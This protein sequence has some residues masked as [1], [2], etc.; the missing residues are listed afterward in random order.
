[1]KRLI[2]LL[3][4]IAVLGPP[5]HAQ[6]TLYVSP[7]V[8]TDDPGGSGSV[9]FPW[10]VVSYKAGLYGPVPVLTLPQNTA[11]DAVHKMD[12]PGNWL[13]S[14][15]A[16]TELPPG[17]GVFFE[18]EDAILY[19]GSNYLMYF[20]GSAAG[21]PP[22]VNV[23]AVFLNRDD[24]GD[25]ILSFDVPTTIGAA[26]Y[27]PADLV[28]YAGGIF[29]L[30]FDASA[31]GSGIAT[32]GNVTGADATPSLDVMSLD[33][34]TDVSP[35]T[36]PTTFIPGLI[37]DWDVPNATYDLYDTLA[38]WPI[39]SEV[40]ALSC[41]ANPGRVYHPTV[42]QFPITMA[43]SSAT[44][45]NVVIYWTTSCSAGAEDYGIY[46]GV[47]G[48]W[49][50]HRKKLCV[51]ADGSPLSEDFPPGPG[52]RY[53]LV[54]PHNFEE[55]GAYGLDYDPTRIPNRVERLQPSAITDRC[56][57]PHI[58]TPCP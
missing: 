6:K 1:M 4:L 32:S 39:S 20:D 49:T 17:G 58:V 15:E 47:I 13:F 42:Y 7:D 35:S 28:R 12:K 5:A 14:V 41:Q 21:V 56:E 57:I 45:G 2:L 30:F 11:L 38:G 36:G 34:P 24:F 54:V 48:T 10:D 33:V 19:D 37:A 55:E 22:G 26:T 18:P 27:D 40:D 52:D 8:P 53:Y 16:P 31:S 25:L 46:E 43:K 29:N 9:F 3:A 44:L 23:D 50:S 51:D